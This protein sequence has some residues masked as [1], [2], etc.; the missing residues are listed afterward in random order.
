M[1][2]H[3]LNASELAMLDQIDATF[4]DDVQKLLARFRE[5]VAETESPQVGGAAM[6]VELRESGLTPELL[7]SYLAIALA[8]LAEAGER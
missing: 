7:R 2:G 3:R 1:T 8:M 5:L 4:R 6:V